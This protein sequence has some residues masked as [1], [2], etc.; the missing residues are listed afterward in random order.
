M[1]EKGQNFL[2]RYTSFMQ[3]NT[4][5]KS[6]AD[7]ALL[8]Y[9]DF[10]KKGDD[11]HQKRTKRAIAGFGDIVTQNRYDF[12]KKGSNV[13][14]E[15]DKVKEMNKELGL[16]DPYNRKQYNE[17]L[18]NMMI[19]GGVI[20]E[21]EAGREAKRNMAAAQQYFQMA[22]AAQE[23][24]ARRR[25]MEDQFSPTKISQ[26]KLRAQQ[27]EAVLMNAIANQGNTAVNIST[28]GLA[29]RGRAGGR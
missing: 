28:A 18:R 23:T 25:L 26:Q 1:S 12:D 21:Y 27:G 15:A 13:K 2:Q 10:D 29:P 8:G 5:F 3:K 14:I 9:T 4:P 16:G 19:T 17:D 7:A 11:I 20:R 6:F 22:G 24:A